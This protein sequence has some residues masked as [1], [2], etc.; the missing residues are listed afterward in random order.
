MA[1]IRVERKRRSLLP[2]L[3]GLLVLVTAALG[4]LSPGLRN[5]EKRAAE[6]DRAHDEPAA[7]P[8]SDRVAPAGVPAE[9][10][11]EAPAE[12]APEPVPALVADGDGAAVPLRR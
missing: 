10:A 12:A 2:L 6:G 7:A 11:P 4:Y 5:L 9:A 8:A 1:E 3:L